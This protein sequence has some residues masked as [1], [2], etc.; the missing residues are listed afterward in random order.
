MS[1]PPTKKPATEAAPT[2]MHSLAIYRLKGTPDRRLRRASAA[3]TTTTMT[4]RRL[5]EPIEP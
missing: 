1:W 2:K 4:A 5:N 3:A